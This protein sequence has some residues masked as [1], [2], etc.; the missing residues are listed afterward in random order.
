MDEI[1]I[2][3]D[4]GQV[5][6]SGQRVSGKVLCHSTKSCDVKSISIKFEG[7]GK[8]EWTE[9]TVRSYHQDGVRHYYWAENPVSNEELFLDKTFNFDSAL[10][11]LNGERSELPPGEHQFQFSFYLPSNIPSSFS[12]NHGY[13]E[14]T[15]EAKANLAPGCYVN[16]KK[17]FIVHNN[18]N[19]NA[20]PQANE[21]IQKKDSKYIYCCCCQSGPI[22][23]LCWIPK[24]G[25][26]VGEKISFSAE[27]ENL[28]S[29]SM[30]KSQLQLIQ[31]VTYHG[32]VCQKKMDRNVI[33]KADR[34]GFEHEDYWTDY[35]IDVPPIPPSPFQG[36]KLIDVDYHIEMEVDVGPWDKNIIVKLPIMIGADF[37]TNAPI[38]FLYP[39][40]PPPYY[41]ALAPP[42]FQEGYSYHSVL[43]APLNPPSYDEIYSISETGC[44]DE[45]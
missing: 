20:L 44:K 15:T 40:P 2:V 23:C 28:S 3:F 6:Y 25:Y 34:P 13:I 18:M 9:K 43:N 22:T 41:E 4:D 35:K 30:E 12:G 16:C 19:V 33:Y 17:T 5:L 31:T 14:Y 36:T 27:I 8:V 37:Q 21:S 42:L 24:Q 1:D 39:I 29:R 45:K 10:A 11:H 38:D 32:K 7:K 26:T